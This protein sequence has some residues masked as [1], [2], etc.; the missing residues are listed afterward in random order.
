MTH[1]T[2]V[3]HENGM[4]VLLDYVGNH[5]HEDHPLMDLHPDWTTNL[6]LPDGSLNTERWD[7]YR[8]TTWFD[9]FMPTLDLERPEVAEAMSDSAAWWATTAAS[10]ASATTRPSTSAK[11]F[12]G[13]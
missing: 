4:N 6:Y 8:L 9:T 12:G 2:D 3:A 5:V 10:T 13:N 11:C 1:L 7:E